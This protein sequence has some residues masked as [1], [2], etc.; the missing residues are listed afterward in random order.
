[1]GIL[2]YLQAEVNDFESSVG[3][4]FLSA[5]NL[6]YNDTAMW[7]YV[8]IAAYAGL[9]LGYGLLL[10]LAVRYRNGYGR[11]EPSLRWMVGLTALWALGLGLLSLLTGGT[12]WS[13][14]ERRTAQIGVVILALLAA[15]FADAF[16]RHPSSWRYR[17]ALALPLALAALAVDI[18]PLQLLL[19]DQAGID[20]GGLLWMLAWLLVSV[21]T[22][23]TWLVAFRQAAGYKHR[24][25]LRHLGLSL[26]AF[27]LGDLLILSWGAIRVPIGL[28]VRLAGLLFAILAVRRHDLPDLRLVA[29]RWLRFALLVGAVAVLYMGVVAIFGY[30]F[31]LYPSGSDAWL[32]I[33]GLGLALLAA[34][35]VDVALS[36]YLVRLLDRILLGPGYN[37]QKALR[38]YSQQSTM[39][40]GLDRLADTTLDWLARTLHVER[41]VFFLFESESKGRTRLE[42]LRATF[43]P[44]PGAKTFGAGSR[45]VAHFSNL[46]RPLSQYDLDMLTWFQLM[47]VDERQWLQGLGLDLYIPVLVGDQP[48]ALLAL[49]SRAGGQPY[50]EADVETLMTLAHQTGTALENA[51]L[52]SDL[53]QLDAQLSETN[54][55]LQDLN[56]ELAETNRQLRRLDQTKTDFVAIASHELRTPLSQ[57][58]GYSDILSSMDGDEL[59]D[60]Q[61]V[62]LFV[63][64][65]SQGAKRLK[66]VVDAMLDVSLIDADAL[67]LSPV[68]FSLGAAVADAVAAVQP[69]AD[70]RAQ[71]ISVEESADMPLVKADRG[72][73]NQVLLGVLGNAIKFTPDGGNIE[74]L[75]HSG[76]IPVGEPHV[77]VD[78]AD[79]GIGIE[80]DQQD[81]V[82]EKFYRAENPLYHSSDDAAYKGA[83]PGL[84][85]AIARGIVEAHGGRIW[86]ESPGRDEATCPGS[87][88]RIR[89]PV[90][91]QIGG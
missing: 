48:V 52:V 74:V 53:Q 16:M 82:F 77:Q 30:V 20:L 57:I 64:G 56:V 91:S 47:P 51:R 67:V 79:S 55:Q 27:A 69:L 13:F 12:W 76:S 90:A 63:Q 14:V 70:Q 59:S 54:Q 37:L 40:L 45:F 43:V 1:M 19:F 88:F 4:I 84:G 31:D 72:R 24:N 78:V 7:L 38:T 60:V 9:V 81:L 41:S 32:V 62:H 11:G 49:G 73:I 80:P 85:L 61:S 23:V 65:I 29:S 42:P 50:A 86:V 71:T 44:V 28:T 22:W 3:R 39:I 25:R 2:A 87:V 75:V 8:Q 35:V 33:T 10:L 36:P 26:T 6:C 21:I 68:E 66:R 89:L 15:E 83:G 46:K 17:L 18:L 58:Y 34:V 5:C